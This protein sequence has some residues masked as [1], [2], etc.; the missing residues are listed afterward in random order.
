MKWFSGEGNVLHRAPKNSV[1][2]DM[3]G[4]EEKQPQTEARIGEIIS[5]LDKP[6]VLSNDWSGGE[7]EGLINERGQLTVSSKAWYGI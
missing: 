4:V 2:F 3:I 7:E 5:T 6:R 1:S